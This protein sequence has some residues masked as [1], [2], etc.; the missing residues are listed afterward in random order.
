[1]TTDERNKAIDEWLK[2]LSVSDFDYAED[3]SKAEEFSRAH[4]VYD[5]NLLYNGNKVYAGT[6]T[7]NPSR[8]PKA[9]DIVEC[10]TQDMMS[11]GQYS[12]MDPEDGMFG[13]MEEFGYLENA[14]SAKMGK[15]AWKGCKEVWDAVSGVFDWIPITDDDGKDMGRLD[16]AAAVFD[17]LNDD[18]FDRSVV[19]F[20]DEDEE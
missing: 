10:L 18:D 12:D 2:K 11:Y 15:K 13:F 19:K 9:I 4:V 6:F 20:E 17:R 16:K 1:M 3:Q 14:K 7:F 8:W 5:F